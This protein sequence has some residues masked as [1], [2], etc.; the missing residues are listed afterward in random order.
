[1]ADFW[2]G[3]GQGFAPAY[4]S[5]LERARSRREK[6]E[7]REYAKKQ[8]QDEIDRLAQIAKDKSVAQA[9]AY[10]DAGVD[11]RGIPT[12]EGQLRGPWSRGNI[13]G[14]QPQ[15]FGPLEEGVE[16]RVGMP[17]RSTRGALG[18]LGEV[19]LMGASA[20]A[21]LRHDKLLEGEKR[22]HAAQLLRDKHD[23]ERKRKR[24]ELKLEGAGDLFKDA[25]EEIQALA[26]LGKKVPKEFWDR[27]DLPDAKVK[28]LNV[29]FRTA[30]A[31]FDA[32]DLKDQQDMIESGLSDLAKASALNPEIKMPPPVKGYENRLPTMT[33][34][35]EAAKKLAFFDRDLKA[36]VDKDAQDKAQ[37]TFGIDISNRVKSIMG[38]KPSDELTDDANRMYKKYFRRVRDDESAEEQLD[39][40]D[41]ILS[42]QSILRTVATSEFFTPQTRTLV[43]NLV[44]DQGRFTDRNHLKFVADN[45]VTERPPAWRKQFEEWK[46]LKTKR[47]AAKSKE[48]K[49]EIQEE[50]NFIHRKANPQEQ[51][52]NLGRVLQHLEEM[53]NNMG[54]GM[55]DG[56]DGGQSPP[57]EAEKPLELPPLPG[58]IGI[59]KKEA[60]P[61]KTPPGA[62]NIETTTKYTPEQK[63]RFRAMKEGD[64]LPIDGGKGF[65][66]KR[67]NLLVPE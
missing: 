43:A 7:D 46:T 57:V 33:R 12:V 58:D 31:E 29:A 17:E 41:G 10:E 62:I 35:W 14:E 38:L 13:V 42:N 48:A 26:L 21:K 59:P 67:G 40:L 45:L 37:G 2:A 50:M 5:S 16:R 9:L 51:A 34:R 56:G 65:L 8:R 36:N 63:A 32:A 55:N 54:N 11:V 44:E 66:V 20:A 47:D 25:R 30:R 1:M 49:A 22:D 23:R 52:T 28:R 24:Q 6:R 18:A 64:R 3:F 27:T 15:P 19:E 61:Q 53:G 4:E 39:E 60:V